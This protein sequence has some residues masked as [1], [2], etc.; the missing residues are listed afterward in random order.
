MAAIQ[1]W[2]DGY[3]LSMDPRREDPLFYYRRAG[4]WEDVIGFEVLPLYEEHT[5][6]EVTISVFARHRPR[7]AALGPEE[8]ERLYVR[9]VAALAAYHDRWR[10]IHLLAED[11][12]VL[13]ASGVLEHEMKNHGFSC[14]P[15]SG[16]NSVTWTRE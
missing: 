3:V 16:P 4:D 9:C 2:P 15:A 6:L 12:A 5:A 7:E 1:T 10:E 11:I 13:L 14:A 8:R